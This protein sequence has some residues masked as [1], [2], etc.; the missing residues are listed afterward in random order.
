MT[1]KIRVR[2]FQSLEDVSL[3]ID[4]LTVVKGANN[5]GKSALMRAIR[6]AFQNTRGT[7]FIRHGSSKSSVQLDFEDGHS[8]VW[9]KG[10]GK[11]DKPTY[12]V[13]GGTPIYPGQG[14]P[15]EVRNLGVRPIQVG[16]KEI[17][18][19]V[20]PQMVGQVFLLDQPGSILAEAVADV[21]RVSQLNEALRMAS[22]DKRLV[23]SEMLTRKKDDLK[24]VQELSRFEGLDD[25]WT[26]L[27][28]IESLSDRTRRAGM[29]LD[30][31]HELRRRFLAA[32]KAVDFY[33]GLEDLALP[34]QEEIL[35]LHD[36]SRDRERL[37]LLHEQMLRA[38]RNVHFLFGVEQVSVP[39]K[40]ALD[41]LTN[42]SALRGELVRLRDH[43][44]RTLS[45][46]CRLEG[47]D[48]V[49]SDVDMTSAIKL[50]QALKMARELQTRRSSAL[51]MALTLESTL[52]S[53]EQELDEVTR[54][55]QEVLGSLGSCPT[56]GLVVHAHGED[57][58]P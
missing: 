54:N 56:C 21:E 4:K 34:D 22:S 30:L 37:S 25:L 17:W 20:A 23:S 43:Y 48:K 46:V 55:L 35:A 12:I 14:V 9:E 2:D 32:T 8:L 33:S 47:V 15:D 36:L 39:P 19:Q 44:E 16:N 52:L 45:R 29:A 11:G 6:G 26:T 5:T 42:Q 40:D 10:T 49:E 27:G 13:D 51:E 58:C 57:R 50:Q 41:Q 38:R 28:D 31:L 24:Y 7:S 53:Q 3:T 1:V 18:P